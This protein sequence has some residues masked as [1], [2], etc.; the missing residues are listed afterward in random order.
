MRSKFPFT[1]TQT[2]IVL[3]FVIIGVMASFIH[4]YQ[5]ANESVDRSL[6]EESLNQR[7]MII[8]LQTCLNEDASPCEIK[9]HWTGKVLP[10]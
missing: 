10:R 6:A 7:L 3:Q 9:D 2:I 5:S 1:L 8:Q 4:F